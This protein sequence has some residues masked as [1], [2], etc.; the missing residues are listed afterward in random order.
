[1]SCHDIGR[2]MNFI[3]RKVMSLRN[4][5]K[6]SVEAARDIISDC[7]RGVWWCDGNPNEAIDYIYSCTCGCCLR[8]VPKGEGLYHLVDSSLPKEDMRPM[9]QKFLT[10]RLCTE[11]FDKVVGDYCKDESAGKREREYI[12]ASNG[13]EESY[14]SDGAYAD[15]NNGLKWPKEDS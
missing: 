14:R 11:C 3:V 10:L 2:A 15:T 7:Y 12:E 1:M 13:W 9:S 4:E 8:L 5:N 6:I